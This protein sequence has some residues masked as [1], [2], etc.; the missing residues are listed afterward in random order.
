MVVKDT[1]ERIVGNLCVFAAM[2]SADQAQH[3]LKVSPALSERFLRHGSR[4]SRCFVEKSAQTF[5][6]IKARFCIDQRSGERIAAKCGFAIWHMCLNIFSS[7]PF[8][9]LRARFRF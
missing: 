7:R 8:L 9:G 1:Q 3:G 2:M 5:A 6:I 4:L